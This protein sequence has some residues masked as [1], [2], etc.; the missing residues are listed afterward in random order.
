ML[1]RVAVGIHGEDIDKVIE[2]TPIH[3]TTTHVVLNFGK[4][5]CNF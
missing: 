1:M 5:M 4:L 2:V 3:Y